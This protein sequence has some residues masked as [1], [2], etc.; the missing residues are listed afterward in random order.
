MYTAFAGSAE[1]EER[2][3]TPLHT[4]VYD[5]RALVYRQE[6]CLPPA[7]CPQVLLVVFLELVFL[8]L[9]GTQR[10]APEVTPPEYSYID[11]STRR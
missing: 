1:M 6:S 7:C 4:R 11:K 3:M 5:T 2:S 10:A 8:E 9:F